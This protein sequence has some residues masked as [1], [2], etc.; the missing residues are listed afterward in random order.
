MKKI[1]T[2]NGLIAYKTTLPEIQ[3]IGG[4]GI[5]DE[6][7]SFHPEGGYLIPV[8]NHWQCQK[9]FNDWKEHAKYYP[10]D[11]EFEAK[12]AKYYETKIPLTEGDVN[13]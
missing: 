6:C 2:K 8:L 1:L 3:S 9:C 5:C 7:G 4:L 13:E 12:T 10:E 11:A